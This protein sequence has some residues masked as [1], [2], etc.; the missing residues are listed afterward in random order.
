VIDGAHA[1]DL[2]TTTPD[3]GRSGSSR[4][5]PSRETEGSHS[6]CA[7]SDEDCFFAVAIEMNGQGVGRVKD[8]RGQ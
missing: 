7:R 8:A 1:K 6:G 3:S 5:Y 2:Q 4:L